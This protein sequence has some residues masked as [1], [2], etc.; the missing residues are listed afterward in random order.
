MWL[1]YLVLSCI[2][3]FASAMDTFTIGMRVLV[4]STDDEVAQLPVKVLEVCNLSLI[5][6]NVARLILKLF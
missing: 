5:V 2:A 6:L 1:L 3:S 4:L